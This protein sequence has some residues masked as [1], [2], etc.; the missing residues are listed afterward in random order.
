MPTVKTDQAKPIMFR[1]TKEHEKAIKA[2]IA[3][4]DLV[5]NKA[6]AIKYLLG[7]GIEAYEAESK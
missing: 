5:D 2:L 1:P 4:K 6:D 7:L 3:K